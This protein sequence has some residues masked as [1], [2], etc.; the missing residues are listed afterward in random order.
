MG[1]YTLYLINR[2]SNRE[3][4]GFFCI[5]FFFPLLLI[6]IIFISTLVDNYI[7]QIIHIVKCLIVLPIFFVLLSSITVLFCKTF[8]KA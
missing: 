6:G 2:G 3:I 5:F 8:I 4:E 1:L 7:E